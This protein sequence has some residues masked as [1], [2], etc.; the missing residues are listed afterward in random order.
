MIRY[1]KDLLAL[2]TSLI[3]D[4]EYEFIVGEDYKE[5]DEIFAN[6]NRYFYRIKR[7]EGFDA[8]LGRYDT[9]ESM[10]VNVG[11]GSHPE[12]DAILRE[13]D[14]YVFGLANKLNITIRE[15]YVYES[16]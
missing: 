13:F 2:A 15:S 16:I 11:L 12:K 9:D 6:I 5:L 8:R 4:V 1:A 10:I 3:P 7:N 14:K